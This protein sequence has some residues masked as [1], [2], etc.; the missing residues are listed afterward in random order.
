VNDSSFS[1]RQRSPPLMGAGSRALRLRFKQRKQRFRRSW[2]YRKRRSSGPVE[3]KRMGKPSDHKAQQ[4]AEN[5]FN[6]SGIKESS[7]SRTTS[8]SSSS[9]NAFLQLP[10]D[11]LPYEVRRFTIPCKFGTPQQIL[12]FQ[13]ANRWRRRCNRHCGLGRGQGQCCRFFDR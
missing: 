11:S 8:I 1:L 10:P 2:H 5:S 13:C 3:P 12:S 7:R 9:A 4:L 6:Y